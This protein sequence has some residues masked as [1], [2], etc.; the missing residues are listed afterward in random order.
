MPARCAGANTQ[1]GNSPWAA[2]RQNKGACS[3]LVGRLVAGAVFGHAITMKVSVI[4]ASDRPTIKADLPAVPVIAL[5][6]AKDAPNVFICNLIF[7][8][9]QQYHILSL[10][11]QDNS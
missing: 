6:P 4:P 7:C 1:L 5:T 3:V 9:P 10:C 2:W 11:R 8:L